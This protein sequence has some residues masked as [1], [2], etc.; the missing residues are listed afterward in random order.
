MLILRTTWTLT[1]TFAIPIPIPNAIPM[2]ERIIG[3][4][5]PTI[6]K[7]GADRSMQHT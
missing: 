4:R 1:L 7:R 3:F 5:V 6:S 2:N